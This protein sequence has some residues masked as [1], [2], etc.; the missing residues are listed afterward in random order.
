M[1]STTIKKL[2]IRDSVSSAV[3][4]IPSDTVVLLVENW[5]AQIKLSGDD[6]LLQSNFV[7]VIEPTDWIVKTTTGDFVKYTDSEIKELYVEVS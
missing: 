1:P 3:Q 5:G 2:A 6:L 4:W 7:E